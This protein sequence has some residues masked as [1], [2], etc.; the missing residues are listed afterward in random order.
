MHRDRNPFKLLTPSWANRN[1]ILTP[2]S[3]LFFVLF[4]LSAINTQ[5]ALP[6][7]VTREEL[8]MMPPYCSAI[9]GRFVGE[10][11]PENHPLRNT[12][13]NCPSVHHYCDALKFVVRTNGAWNNPRDAQYYFKLAD[14]GFAS[15]IEE[16][17]RT[18]PDCTLYPEAHTNLGN[19]LLNGSK[20]GFNRIGDVLTN[21]E[22]AILKNN[23]Y[24]PAYIG[25]ADAYLKYKEKDKAMKVLERG[26]QK[27]TESKQLA[28][29]YKALG[30]EPESFI[31][32]L[33]VPIAKQENAVPAQTT[34]S[35]AV[36]KNISP[37]STAPKETETTQKHKEIQAPQNIGSPANP[38][39]RFCPA[40]A[41]AKDK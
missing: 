32:S 10:P 11:K 38:W 19:H 27:N 1:K 26:L 33:P 21:F 30:G 28:R 3:V 14:S 18:S 17:R 22:A 34:G 36:G 25:L 5:A 7:E 23:N 40:T 41:P 15:V 20:Y 13:P 29:K 6:F 8:R 39:C 4:N 2:N 35:S 24:V 9:Y 31:A 12:I 37:D 16:W